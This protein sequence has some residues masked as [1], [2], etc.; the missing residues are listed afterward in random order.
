MDVHTTAT[1]ILESCPVYKVPLDAFGPLGQGFSAL[2]AGRSSVTL[3]GIFVHPGV[4][5]ADFTGQI[6]AVVSTPTPPLPFLKRLE[7]FNLCL[8]SHVF[9]G[10]NNTATEMVALDLW[11]FCRSSG[12]LI[13]PAKSRR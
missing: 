10:Q 7:L 4:I 9:L 8:L 13:S 5:D 11:G 3:K 1:V 12:V 2:L 6:C